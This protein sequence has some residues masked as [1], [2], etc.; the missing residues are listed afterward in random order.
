MN[1]FRLIEN[2]HSGPV[3]FRR[4]AVS[5]RH[6]RSTSEGAADAV[7]RPLA[8]GR[9]Q[10]AGEALELTVVANGHVPPAGVEAELLVSSAG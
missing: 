2:G 10:R 1:E 6:S 9:W 5:I 4:H 8:T 7:R 3:P